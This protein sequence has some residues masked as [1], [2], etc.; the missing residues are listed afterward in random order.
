VDRRELYTLTGSIIRITD[1]ESHR[2]HLFSVESAANDKAMIRP[3]NSEAK[4]FA[5]SRREGEQLA[6][7]AGTSDG[8]LHGVITVERYLVSSRMLMI[9]NP[10]LEFEQRRESFRVVVALPITVGLPRGDEL[11]MVNATTL[12]VSQGGFAVTFADAQQL[13]ATGE[14]LPAVL[15]A[16]AETVVAVVEMLGM[17]PDRKAT[18]RARFHQIAPLDQT[19]LA[20]DLRRI[21]V[22]KV[23]TQRVR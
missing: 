20:A 17:H 4:A 22:T 14:L 5:T 8:V 3:C 7:N 1:P 16:P 9:D 18:M 21:E 15:Q 6:V 12:D 2:V 10:P 13:P 11:V 23:R 19:L